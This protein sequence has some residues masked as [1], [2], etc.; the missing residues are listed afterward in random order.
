MKQKRYQIEN[1]EQLKELE[2]FSKTG[3][4]NTL[5]AVWNSAIRKGSAAAW[6][7]AFHVTFASAKNERIATIERDSTGGT[8]RICAELKYVPAIKWCKEN[9]ILEN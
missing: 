2:K 3:K 9:L 1:P 5:I 7:K 4:L 6:Q 8:V